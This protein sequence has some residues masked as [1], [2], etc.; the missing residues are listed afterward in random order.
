MSLSSDE[1]F[2]DALKSP[3][4]VKLIPLTSKELFSALANYFTL[5]FI[6]FHITQ[7]KLLYNL[8]LKIY[9]IF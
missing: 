1:D 6:E 8:D 3:Q 9:V 2:V 7:K 4:R 5:I